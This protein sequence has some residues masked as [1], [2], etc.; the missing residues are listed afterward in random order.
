M[1]ATI[2][3]L[4]PSLLLPRVTFNHCFGQSGRD[5]VR[6]RGGF[7]FLICSLTSFSHPFLIPNQE[8]QVVR[9]ALMYATRK[10]ST[11]S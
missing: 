11:A 6:R 5:K 4:S 8:R 7:H 3:F 2:H 9:R 10:R 1:L